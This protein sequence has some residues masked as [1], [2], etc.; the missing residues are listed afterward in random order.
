MSDFVDG[1]GK[2]RKIEKGWYEW[3]RIDDNRKRLE[4]SEERDWEWLEKIEKVARVGKDRE[5]LGSI[6]IFWNN[7]E[8]LVRVQK[9]WK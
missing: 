8:R 6:D 9:D 4:I 7:W 1:F 5:E 2:I 3:G